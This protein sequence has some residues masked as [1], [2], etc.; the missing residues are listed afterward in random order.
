MIDTKSKI[1]IG[2][3]I[4][5]VVAI[6]F[7]PFT[8]KTAT[9]V[10]VNLGYGFLFDPPKSFGGTTGSVNIGL[11]LVELFVII[12]VGTIII[13]ASKKK[14]G[15]TASNVRHKTRIKPIT[16]LPNLL[17]II[18]AIIC[19]LNTIVEQ[20]EHTIFYIIGYSL[21]LSL[22][23]LI[24]VVVYNLTEDENKIAKIAS[25]IVTVIF[26]TLLIGH[27]LLKLSE[28]KTTEIPP[29]S[30]SASAPA[31]APGATVPELAPAPALAPESA[32]DW[33]NKAYAL[34]SSGICSSPQEA[35]EYLNEAIRLKPYFAEA[36]CIRGN[37]YGD[38]RQYQQAIKDYDE[39][40]R[41]KPD[42]AV[43]YNNRGNAYIGSGN[44]QEGCRSLIRACELGYCKG[45]ERMKQNG[46]CL[47]TSS[48]KPPQEPEK[49]AE[50]SSSAIS[51]DE[52]EQKPEKN[53]DSSTDAEQRYKGI[54]GIVL[55]N[56]NVIKGQVLS[57]NSNIIEIRTKDGKI[58]SYDFK[59]DV[60]TFIIK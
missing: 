24:F 39:A 20:Y 11:L 12:I 41:L 15:V 8:F 56:G 31:P 19:F 37:A 2:I 54:K 30:I 13:I 3:A 18:F 59:K 23:P 5:M 57:W 26:I 34:C 6:L 53:F 48:D 40:I 25:S 17:F 43:F 28:T 36:Y 10:V 55:K 16:K 58:L 49:N 14:R 52:T 35:I 29:S 9:G 50:S 38:L 7:P 60:Q 4:A 1:L 51:P 22:I 42:D 45:Y 27:I 46:Y 44:S 47:V 33:F 32:E 21:G